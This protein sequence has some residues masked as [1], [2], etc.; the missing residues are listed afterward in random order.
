MNYPASLD[1]TSSQHRSWRGWYWAGN[2]PDPPTLPADARWSNIDD[3]LPGNWMIRGYGE[4]LFFPSTVTIEFLVEVT[5][6]SGEIVNEAEVDYS[7]IM[8]KDA[9]VMTIPRVFLY[10]PLIMKDF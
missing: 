7:G 2:P 3:F 4:T 1:Q 8:M 9:H 10:M 5:A 6:M